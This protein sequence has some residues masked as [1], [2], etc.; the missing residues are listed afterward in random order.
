MSKLTPTVEWIWKLILLNM[1]WIFF[2]FAGLI[3]FGLFPATIAMFS[4]MRKWMMK[5]ETQS[6]FR[7]Y[8]GYYKSEF[9]RS[10]M[11]SVFLGIFV[12]FILIDWRLVQSMDSSVTIVLYVGLVSV[13]LATLFIFIYLFPLYV[14]YEIAFLD[15]IKK[16]LFLAILNPILTIGMVVTGLFLYFLFSA[17]PFLIPFL[18]AS[19]YCWVF[20]KG[21]YTVFIRNEKKL[22]GQKELS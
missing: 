1:L 20:M 3:V 16:S 12:Y 4:I 17:V 11:L 5:K 13:V 9:K 2:T 7:E 18:G 6:L 8:W 19:T 14:H 22:Q 21:A 10:N 15:A